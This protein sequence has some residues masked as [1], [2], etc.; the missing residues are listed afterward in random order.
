MVWAPVAILL[1]QLAKEGWMLK[2][3][4]SLGAFLRCFGA[5]RGAGASS[6]LVAQHH[7]GAVL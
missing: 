7:V 3:G 6:G 4:G 5:G 1:A 2:A